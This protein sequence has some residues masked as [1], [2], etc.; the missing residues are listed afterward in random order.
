MERSKQN[1]TIHGVKVHEAL[2]FE[3]HGIVRL[4]T[5]LGS[6][7]AKHIL[8]PATQARNVPGKFRFR[9]GFGYSQ[10]PALSHRDHAVESFFS[11]NLAQGSAHCCEGQR[12][13]RERTSNPAYVAV[14]QII[15]VSG[16]YAVSN[17]VRET[18]GRARNASANSFAKDKHVGFEV[19][20][21]RIAAG[22]G[23]DGVGLI[24]DEQHAVF[25]AEFPESVMIAGGGMHDANIGHRRLSQYAS[26][27]S[28]SER[29]LQCGNVVE[30]D[31]L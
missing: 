5:V 6:I 18:V 16:G 27:V 4:G 19:L 11:Q 17:V 28:G 23:T 29:A 15:F 31:H 30:L 20:G 21:P 10:G 3:V 12:V 22:S 24:D 14:L 2:Q 13:A 26:Y 7:G 25:A 1:S 8:G 9:D